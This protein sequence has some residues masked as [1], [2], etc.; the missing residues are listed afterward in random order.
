MPEPDRVRLVYVLL[1]TVL[2]FVKFHE[3]IAV[4]VV[5]IV[6]VPLAIFIVPVLLRVPPDMLRAYAPP[7]RSNVPVVSDIYRVPVTVT[8]PAAV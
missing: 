1:G 5:G 6:I 4:R 2:V 7:E 8:E 3:P